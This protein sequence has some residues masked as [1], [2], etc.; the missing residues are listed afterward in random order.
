MDTK[1]QPAST[2][3]VIM[4]NRLICKLMCQNAMQRLFVIPDA[5]VFGSKMTIESRRK[6]NGEDTKTG[7]AHGNSSSRWMIPTTFS[8]PSFLTRQGHLETPYTIS[9]EETA[10]K[11]NS[12]EN[13]SKNPDDFRCWRH[14]YGPTVM[15]MTVVAA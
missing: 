1:E 14:S 7:L 15:M 13:T 9:S 6:V 11:K 8:I 12:T 10:A 2:T 4:S 5:V 3:F